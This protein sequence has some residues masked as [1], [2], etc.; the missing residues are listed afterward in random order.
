MATESVKTKKAS[1]PGRTKVPTD[2]G[3]YI[4]H[5]RVKN[6]LDTFGINKVWDDAIRTLRRAEP[7]VTTTVDPETKET[8][9][10]DNPAVPL[11]EL[12]QELLDL[13]EESKRLYDEYHKNKKPSEANDKK[14]TKKKKKTSA[15]GVPKVT[16]YSKEISWIARRKTRF[17][18]NIA[19]RVSTLLCAMLHELMGFGMT[20]VLQNKQKTLKKRHIFSKGVEKLSFYKLYRELPVF[21]RGALAEERRRDAV[22]K[23]EEHRNKERQEKRRHAYKDK[24]SLAVKDTNESDEV[25]RVAKVAKSSGNAHPFSVY[26]LHICQDVINIIEKKESKYGSIQ[27]SDEVRGF[28][29]QLVLD[30]I[31]MICPVIST[32]VTGKRQKTVSRDM[33]EQVL[34]INM[35]IAG[36]DVDQVNELLDSKMNMYNQFNLRKKED[37]NKTEATGDADVEPVSDS[38]EEEEEEL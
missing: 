25:P 27:I 6:H 26:I 11:K 36:I 32:I 12:G 17:S 22:L 35:M 34:D 33:M 23:K 18:K 16:L 29:S 30:Y 10:V 37:P 3:C 38:E 20:N 15:R 21:I 13:L 19:A 7:S 5:A 4:P 14:S 31:K 9:V 24:F 1:V 2:K 8:T 28:G